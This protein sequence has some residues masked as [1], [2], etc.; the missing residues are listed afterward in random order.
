VTEAKIRL[1]SWEEEERKVS[2]LVSA[3]DSSEEQCLSAAKSVHED[4]RQSRAGSSF[5]SFSLSTRYALA[6]AQ[7]ELSEARKAGT[8]GKHNVPTLILHQSTVNREG[9]EAVG[10]IFVPNSDAARQRLSAV[11]ADMREGL[12]LANDWGLNTPDFLSAFAEAR[13]AQL[14]SLYIAVQRSVS[15]LVPAE[16]RLGRLEQGSHQHKGQTG[17]VDKQVETV[18]LL[19][20]RIQ[21]WAE[22]GF[23]GLKSKVPPGGWGGEWSIGQIRKGSRP[24]QSPGLGGGDGSAIASLHE[25]EL[26]CARSRSQPCLFCFCAHLVCFRGQKASRGTFCSAPR[27]AHASDSLLSHAPPRL[28][29]RLIMARNGQQRCEEE[30]SRTLLDIDAMKA[31]MS[32]CVEALERGEAELER[33]AEVWRTWAEKYDG[34]VAAYQVRAPRP[35]LC[36]FS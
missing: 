18:S 4:I 19:Y 10:R 13:D 27:F 15:I 25:E 2:S 5:Q 33:R 36:C 24:W 23:F 26:G 17:I 9:P 30:I 8:V 28:R 29:R 31:N 3:A 16:G 34:L 35:L 20:A 22:G 21:G 12:N 11:R 32:R 6:L 14:Q 7:S 1:K